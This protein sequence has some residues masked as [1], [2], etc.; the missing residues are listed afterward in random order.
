ME[1]NVVSA[2]MLEVPLSGVGTVHRLERC[3]VNG[4]M[5]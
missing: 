4:Q 2:Q 5:T 3:V 1:K